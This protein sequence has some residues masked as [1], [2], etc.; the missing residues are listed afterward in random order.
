[1]QKIFTAWASSR[2]SP[3]SQVAEDRNLPGMVVARLRVSIFGGRP[4]TRR[5]VTICCAILI[6]FEIGLFLFAVAGTY[7]LIVPLRRPAT[8]DFVSF[9]AA[10]KLAAAGTPQLAYDQIAHYAA[11]QHAAQPGIQYNYFYYPPIFLIVCDILAHFPYLIAFGL[12]EA[13]TL[14]LYLLVA[15]QILNKDSIVNLVPVLA[16]PPVFWTIGMG[17]NAFLT[18]ALFGAA[19]FFIDRRPTVAGLLFG[20]LC[21]KP[22]FALLVPVAL[23]AGRHWRAFA[24]TFASAA[25]LSSVS[26]LLFGRPTWDAFLIAAAASPGVYGSGRIALG[27]FVT[28]FGAVLLLGGGLAFAYAVQAIATI[29]AAVLVAV[30]WHRADPLPIRAAILAAATLVAVP[31]AIVYDLMLASIAGLWLLRAGEETRLRRREG[32]TLAGLSALSLNPRALAEHWHLPVGAAISLV[33]FV[34][35]AGIALRDGTRTFPR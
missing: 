2:I 10:G 8:T 14:A 26:L 23:I 5:S 25:L 19:T 22:H 21:Y 33:L 12:F 35:V 13:T 28:P 16:L 1:L 29:S 7:G 31:L 27:G 6:V 17:Q 30:V 20:G 15:H 24:A 32:W 3:A 9:F 11:E 34:L 18:A 4:L